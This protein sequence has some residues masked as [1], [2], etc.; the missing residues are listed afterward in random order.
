M[1]LKFVGQSFLRWNG[2]R[3]TD[4]GFN[5]TRVSVGTLPHGSEWQKN[6]VPRD[7]DQW[8]EEGPAFEPHCPNTKERPCMG[9]PPNLEVVD[10]VRIPA[11]LKPGRY[12][13]GWRW[14]VEETMQV[15]QSCSDVTIV[16]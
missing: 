9:N 16:A 11:G 15:W 1:P 3:S 13:L 7:F 2:D 5:A 10:L 4:L 8:D 12:V 14:D 6:P